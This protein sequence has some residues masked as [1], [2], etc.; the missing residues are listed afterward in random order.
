M[1]KRLALKLNSHQQQNKKKQAQN[2]NTSMNQ[3]FVKNP[4]E[5]I[6]LLES[7]NASSEKKKLQ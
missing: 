5:I 1:M 6:N 2:R 4:V 3:K 7:K